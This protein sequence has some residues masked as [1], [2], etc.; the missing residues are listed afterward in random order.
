MQ[1]PEG[2]DLMELAR[3]PSRRVD[4]GFGGAQDLAREVERVM[5][6]LPEEQRTAIIL[7]EFHD[8]R[9]RKSLI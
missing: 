6:R 4:R 8:G 7:K 2:V 9:S 1:A 5:A 3:Q